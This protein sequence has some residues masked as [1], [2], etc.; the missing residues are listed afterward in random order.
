MCMAD[1]ENIGYAIK[2]FLD[3]H[4]F[5]NGL[6]MMGGGG[7]FNNNMSWE[8]TEEHGERVMERIR[9]VMND[10]IT[11]IT[12]ESIFPEDI[13]EWLNEYMRNLESQWKILD[14]EGRIA[15]IEKTLSTYR[16]LQQ[17]YGA[18]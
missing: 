16:Q 7:R 14:I 1:E 4:W 18:R 8:R 10:P 5:E 13:L 9:R 17:K 12:L 6:V 3:H 11:N 15:Y 2:D